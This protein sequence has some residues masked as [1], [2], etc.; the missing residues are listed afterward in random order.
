VST[1][2]LV[3]GAWQGGWSWG[4]VIPRL[5]AC[6][7]AVHAPTLTGLGERAHL[8]S[9]EVSLST[10]IEDV[11]GLLVNEQLK[12]ITL[13]GHSYGGQVIA[14]VASRRPDL[15]ARLIYLD[16]FLPDDGQ[17]ATEEQP[18]Q[19]AHHYAESVRERG[20]GWLIPP[21]GLEVLGVTEPADVDWLTQ[22]MVPHPYRTFNEPA[23]VTPESLT[24]ASAYIECVDWMRVFRPQREKAEARGWP[25]SEL[26]TGHQA[27]TTA[28]GPLA[29]R[30]DELSMTRGD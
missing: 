15:L 11:L 4:R 12:D 9:P 28:A 14:G 20:F 1:F 16:A 29:K 13:V 27:M 6:G 8:L 24:I 7:H 10:H 18:P 25:V 26:S 23:Q 5:R 30:L 22:L 2:V 19:I 17:S 3:A 21:R